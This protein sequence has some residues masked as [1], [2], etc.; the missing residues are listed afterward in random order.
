MGSRGRSEPRRTVPNVRPFAFRSVATSQARPPGSSSLSHTGF[1]ALV[2]RCLFSL[3]LLCSL[4]H[5]RPGIFIG[6]APRPAI[7]VARP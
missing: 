4:T 3:L 7:P 6:T 1:R 2:T 5:L